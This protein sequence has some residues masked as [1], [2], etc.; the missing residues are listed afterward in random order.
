[1]NWVCDKD[2][3]ILWDFYMNGDECKYFEGEEFCLFVNLFVI[4]ILLYLDVDNVKSEGDII[5]K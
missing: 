1:M 2:K 3:F 5:E 4:F